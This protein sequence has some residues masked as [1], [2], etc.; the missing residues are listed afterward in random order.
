DSPGASYKPSGE[1]EKKDTEDTRNADNEAS[2]TEEPS[3]NQEKDS[4]N[5]TNIFNA[6]SLAVNAASN[7]VN[8]VGR[9]SS[10]ELPDD[11]NMPEL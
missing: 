9:K 2:I 8:D 7:E 11:P 4:V 6:V 3:V 5:N 1:K 10:I